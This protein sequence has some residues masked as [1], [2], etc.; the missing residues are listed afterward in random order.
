MDAF[1]LEKGPLVKYWFSIIE[2]IFEFKSRTKE[3]RTLYIRTRK[4]GN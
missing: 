3:L 2:N 4:K 1:S